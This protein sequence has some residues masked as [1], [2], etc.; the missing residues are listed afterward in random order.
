MISPFELIKQIHNKDW[1]E[2]SEEEQNSFNIFMINRI[3]SMNR[4]NIEYINFIQRYT[5]IPP[6]L[7]YTILRSFL[8][9]DIR[10]FQW[11]KSNFLTKEEF[12]KVSDYLGVSTREAKYYVRLLS[13][14]QISH[15]LSEM[16]EPVFSYNKTKKDEPEHNKRAIKSPRKR[17]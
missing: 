1:N 2:L 5:L 3:I 16:N 13:P 7:Y 11:I 14:D 4:S 8:S 6:S 12:K 17:T 10:K 15:I 9:K